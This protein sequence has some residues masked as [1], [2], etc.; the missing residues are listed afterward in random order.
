MITSI[1]AHDLNDGDKITFDIREIDD[2]HA[3]YNYLIHQR[4]AIRVRV[5]LLGNSLGGSIVINYATF[6][7]DI[8]AVV[9]VSAFS[10]LQDTIN[11]LV[12]YF[13]DLP[14]FPFAP[15]ISF[16]A[17]LILGVDVE[18]VN[19]TKSAASLC[20]TP[21]FIMQGGQDIVISVESG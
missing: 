11:V 13:T 1:R 4:G 15:M 14:A 20:H 18:Q 21:L 17:E 9:A 5:G 16:W 12:E 10:S 19:A 7:R 3:W 8:A 2:L 6:N